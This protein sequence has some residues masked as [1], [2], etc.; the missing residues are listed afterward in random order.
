MQ[1]ALLSLTLIALIFKMVLWTALQMVSQICQSIRLFLSRG[2]RIER[3]LNA[4]LHYEF[5]IAFCN[6]RDD[7]FTCQWA[8]TAELSSAKWANKC[9]HSPCAYQC[10]MV[11]NVDRIRASPVPHWSAIGVDLC[12]TY[13]IVDWWVPKMPDLPKQTNTPEMM[14]KIKSEFIMRGMPYGY[15]VCSITKL[16]QTKVEHTLKC[17]SPKSIEELNIWC[18]LMHSVWLSMYLSALNRKTKSN[19]IF[20]CKFSHR[21]EQWTWGQRDD[22]K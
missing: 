13:S 20:E 3:M 5:I 19:Y 7:A 4:K 12:Y 1:S 17:S 21:I 15:A 6:C 14:S 2:N 9:V 16:N 11:L 22:I 8:P 18:E 10:A